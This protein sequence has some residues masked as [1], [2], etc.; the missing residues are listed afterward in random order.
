MTHVEEITPATPFER[1]NLVPSR[2]RLQ[3][4]ASFKKYKIELP[5]ARH[6]K[7]KR[8]MPCISAERRRTLLLLNRF[9]DCAEN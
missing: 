1:Q 8:L 3:S 6:W 7:A 4:T 2:H 9:D 5:R